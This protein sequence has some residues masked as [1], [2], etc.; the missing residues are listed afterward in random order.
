MSKKLLPPTSKTKNKAS[1]LSNKKEGDNILI[2]LE[3]PDTESEAPDVTLSASK[4]ALR[5]WKLENEASELA[6]G[7]SPEWGPTVLKANEVTNKIMNDSLMFKQKPLFEGPLGIK[8]QGENRLAQGFEQ[9]AVH[10]A[11]T[12]VPGAVIAQQIIRDSGS[13]D[14]ITVETWKTAREQMNPTSVN[15]QGKATIGNYKLLTEKNIIDSYKAFITSPN[16]TK[17]FGCP[18][19][20]T[21]SGRQVFDNIDSTCI[22]NYNTTNQVFEFGEENFEFGRRTNIGV[23]NNEI[24]GDIIKEISCMTCWL[25]N[26]PLIKQSPMKQGKPHGKPEPPHTEHVLNILDALFYLDLFETKDARLMIDY[27]CYLG[28]HYYDQGKWSIAPTKAGFLGYINSVYK[29]NFVADNLTIYPGI[30]SLKEAWLK[31]HDFK[32]EYLYAH[33]DC[34]YE[35]NDDSLLCINDKD[36]NLVFNE[37][38]ASNLAERIWTKRLTPKGGLLD[39]LGLSHFQDKYNKTQWKKN[40]LYSWR[41]ILEPT[42][43][44]INRKRGVQRG[45]ESLYGFMTLGA[46]IYRLPNTIKEVMINDKSID[47][48]GK[49]SLEK[50]KIPLVPTDEML[51]TLMHILSYQVGN[52]ASEHNIQLDKFIQ[53]CQ[54]HDSKLHDIEIASNDT[55]IPSGRMTRGAK[56]DATN[57]V[58]KQLQIVAF[59]KLFENAT[60]Y[61]NYLINTFSNLFYSLS[62]QN[63][64]NR[65]TIISLVVANVY[66]E[67]IN[68]FVALAETKS[69]DPSNDDFKSALKQYLETEKAIKE[70]IIRDLNTNSGLNITTDS[71][72]YNDRT[73]TGYLRNYNEDSEKYKAIYNEDSIKKVANFN[74]IKEV[75]SFDFEESSIPNEIKNSAKA[76]FSEIKSIRDE[77][78][79]MTEDL[80][81]LKN[82]NKVEAELTDLETLVE[83]AVAAD[84]ASKQNYSNF[85]YLKV[86]PD[87]L[88]DDADDHNIF[89]TNRYITP[90]ESVIGNKRNRESDDEFVGKPNKKKQRTIKKI[91]SNRRTTRK[92]GGRY[93][94]TR[95]HN[96]KRVSRKYIPQL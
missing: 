42:A 20:P 71:L 16:N 58:K 21:L 59:N 52:L 7:R 37:A 22:Y 62:D 73:S 14:F 89:N 83:T 4:S 60:N 35:K 57:L 18:V 72:Q 9:T 96:K 51:L 13:T 54:L 61:L 85:D 80:V 19:A 2:D 10:F 29:Q 90:I 36:T 46:Y 44:Y 25:C 8:N 87:Y 95:K 26:L 93:K 77:D 11:I 81:N 82:A 40:I 64:R 27:N 69:V 67:L 79:K 24:E 28:Q 94:K 68:V 48:D 86:A 55:S 38:M 49:M 47:F 65:N 23:P 66:I 70:G 75:I 91:H 12:K 39:S 17:C 84:T 63:E 76:K 56:N 88:Y 6:K 34:N 32:L 78:I 43:A 30:G 50:K 41:Q 15:A 1:L 31:I 3:A 74:P 92:N 45:E 5:R 53:F 33:P